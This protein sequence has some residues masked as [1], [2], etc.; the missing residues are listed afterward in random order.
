MHVGFIGLGLMGTEIAGNLIKAGH[1]VTVWNRSADKA[2]PLVAAGATLA[3][4]PAEAA[5]NPVVMSMLAD[6][7]ALEA[8]VFGEERHP[9]RPAGRPSMSR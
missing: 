4:T 9:P 2:A 1:Q 6:D 3:A 7:K 8:V 5:R